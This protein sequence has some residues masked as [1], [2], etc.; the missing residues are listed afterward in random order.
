MRKPFPIL[1]AALLRRAKEGFQK[2]GQ[3]LV[4]TILQSLHMKDPIVF[5]VDLKWVTE[6]EEA[7][8]FR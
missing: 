7:L 5:H 1:R 8:Q 4:F 6:V 3:Q 2:E